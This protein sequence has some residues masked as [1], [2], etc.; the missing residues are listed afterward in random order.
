MYVIILRVNHYSDSKTQSIDFIKNGVSYYL[1][2]DGLGISDFKTKQEAQDCFGYKECHKRDVTWSTSACIHF[3]QYQPVIYE[4]DEDLDIIKQKF[5][6]NQEKIN[7][8]SLSSMSG[9]LQGIHIESLELGEK[10]YEEGQRV[11]LI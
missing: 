3:M 8:H 10:R 1:L 6:P 11:E 5:F 9:R 7:C 2:S 4:I